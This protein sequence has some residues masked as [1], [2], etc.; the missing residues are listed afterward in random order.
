[1]TLKVYDTLRRKK[2]EFKPVHEGKVGIYFCGMTVQGKPHMGHMLAFVAG[3]IIKRYL[4]FVG[5]DVTY[6]Q[7]F[8]DVD[9]KI[10]EKAN[11]EGVDFH[12]IA[13]RYIAEYFKYEKELN[14]LP[15]DIYPKATEHIDDIIGLVQR[16]VDRDLAYQ[17]GTDVYFRVRDCSFY[18]KLSGRK[19]DELQSG[20]RIE[21]EEQKEDPLDFTLWKGAREGE[22]AWDSPWGRGRPGWHIEC[23][24]MSMKYLG[25]TIDMHG[26]GLDLIFP[27]HENEIAQSESATGNPYVKYW[28]HNG[29]LNLQG[30]K[31]SKSTGHFFS[32][33]DIVKEFPGEVIRFYLLSTHFRSTT[34]FGRERLKEASAGF[35]RIRNLCIYLGELSSRQRASSGVERSGD[36]KD[37]V[38]GE[39]P[40]EK[41]A[42]QVKV[43]FLEAMDDDFNSGEAVG[44]IF[45]LVREV[46]RLKADDPSL[47]ENDRVGVAALTGLMEMFDGI[48]GLF[49]D[50]LPTGDVEVPEDII[51]LVR[52]REDARKNKDWARA[53]EIRAEVAA[54]GY[55]IEDGPDG[56]KVKPS[57]SVE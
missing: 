50:G 53:D 18:G 20:A 23:S 45:R 9:D 33:E 49:R 10:I 46:N 43:D 6:L 40:L 42:A 56:S 25:D 7:N 31:M 29:L 51:K 22:P 11:A 1:M 12:V 36:G 28:M 14:I 34:E 38:T 27:H 3:D 55:T 44:H 24:A 16:L 26:G 5:Y 54:A 35:D 15:A 32:I 8:T 39:S 13:E 48:L 19:I 47:I 2:E 21:V 17:G 52:E 41:L 4:R 30:E 37:T 57:D